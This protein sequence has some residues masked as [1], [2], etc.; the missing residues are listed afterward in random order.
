[1]GEKCELNPDDYN[2][3]SDL[4]TAIEESDEEEGEVEAEPPERGQIYSY[5]PLRARSDVTVEV[6]RVARAKETCNVKSIEEGKL[7]KGVP[8]AK[9]TLEE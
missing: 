2:T 6:T 3:W 4:A 8:W 5:R 7:F 9:L 1:M